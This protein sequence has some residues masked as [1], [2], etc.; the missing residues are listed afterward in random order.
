M[1]L[2]D[3]IQKSKLRYDIQGPRALSPI[4][5]DFALSAAARV[6]ERV[7]GLNDGTNVFTRDWDVLVILD[8]CRH[9]MYERRVRECEA[10]W[11]V[12]GSSAEWMTK[13]F[14]QADADVLEQTA[15]VTSNPF[16]TRSDALND[17]ELGLLDEVW[18]DGWDD[19]LG[20]VPARP[21]T[22]HGIA[23]ARTGEFERVIVHYMQPHYPFIADLEE[24]ET[25]IGKL[26]QENFG[27]VGESLGMWD[28]VLLGELDAETVLEAYDKNLDYVMSDVRLLLENT[29]GKAVV[30]ADH[31]NALGEWGQWGHR[32]AIP[33]PG[34]RRVPWD[35]RECTDEETYQPDIEHSEVAQGDVDETVSSRLQELGYLNE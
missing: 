15:Y 13:T 30:S 23:A 11:S 28:R 19:G 8:A 7:P 5:K 1:S 34:M 22:D 26:D 12:A 35:I 9:D 2:Q 17:I 18:R 14:G 31:G 21:V 32:P 25:P 24:G 16:S 20:T 3:F 29:D 4:A 33:H 27:E 6:T 10:I